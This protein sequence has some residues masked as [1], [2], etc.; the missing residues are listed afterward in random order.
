MSLFH[1]PFLPC[2]YRYVVVFLLIFEILIL[3]NIVKPISITILIKSYLYG[4][5]SMEKESIEKRNETDG[6]HFFIYFWNRDRSYKEIAKKIKRNNIKRQDV[7]LQVNILLFYIKWSILC[8]RNCIQVSTD[9]H[10]KWYSQ[11]KDKK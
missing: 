4:N 2:P 9:R 7:K 8:T 1:L 5:N 6:R 10:V 11:T 3:I